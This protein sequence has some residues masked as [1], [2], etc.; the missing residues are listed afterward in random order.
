[1]GPFIV[2]RS[3]LLPAILFSIVVLPSPTLASIRRDLDSGMHYF[4]YDG[5]SS[6][7]ASMKGVGLGLKGNGS[8]LPFN[9]GIWTPILDSPGCYYRPMS[10]S[11]RYDLLRNFIKYCVVLRKN[12]CFLID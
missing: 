4:C 10:D 11:T 5:S 3:R 1:M 6:V 9:E 7:Y 12:Y 2:T 8:M